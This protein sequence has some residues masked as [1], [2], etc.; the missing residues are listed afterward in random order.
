MMYLEIGYME[1][2]IWSSSKDINNQCDSIKFTL[3]KEEGKSLPFLDVLITNNP[4][5]SLSHH[6]YRKKMYTDIYLHAESHHHPS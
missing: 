6:V 1:R 3:E 5:G 4:D 2:I